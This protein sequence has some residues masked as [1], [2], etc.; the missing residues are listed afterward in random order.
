MKS[1]LT[2]EELI[3][4]YNQGSLS[5][6]DLVIAEWKLI[7]D[8]SFAEAVEVDAMVN[9]VVLGNALADVRHQMNSDLARLERNRKTKIK[10]GIA[11]LTLVILSVILTTVNWATDEQTNDSKSEIE[12]TEIIKI[13]KEEVQV[14]PNGNTEPSINFD[15]NTTNKP[16]VSEPVISEPTKRSNQEI[17]TKDDTV[18]SKNSTEITKEYVDTT[19]ELKPIKRSQEI[20]T[21]CDLN[22]ETKSSASCNNRIDG[23]IQV[24]ISSVTGATKPFV[25]KLEE[26]GLESVG[27]TFLKISPGAY[28]VTLKDN[29]GCV[30]KKDVT[31][32][33]K[34]CLP[35]NISFNPNYGEVARINVTDHDIVHLQVI[36]RLGVIVFQKNIDPNEAL[37]WN[38][39]TISGEVTSAGSYVCI[40]VNS[41]GEKSTIQLS[42]LK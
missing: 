5:A 2:I 10:T 36:N 16:T 41:K 40:L 32:E 42:V 27:G 6:K 39:H 38:G 14:A 26:L 7:N 8:P 19:S 37:E 20:T 21:L 25:F 30:L 34:K 13:T 12:D 28:T 22:F 1:D 35:D 9:E 17:I 18:T 29:K 33:E 11:V 23:E 31:V 24:L 15:Q 4:G 3:N